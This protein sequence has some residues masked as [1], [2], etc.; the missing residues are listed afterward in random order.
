METIRHTK[1]SSENQTVA[2]DLHGNCYLNITNRCTLRCRFCP[3]FNKQWDVQSYSL[4]LTQEPD[5]NEVLNAVGDPSQYQQIVFCGLGESTLRLVDVLGIAG[6]IKN[7]GGRVRINTDGLINWVK[8]ED[9]TPLFSGVIDALSISLNAQNETVY[10]SHCRPPGHGAYPAL[11]DFIY[12]VRA[13]VENI[14]VTAIDGLEGVD[15]DACKEIADVLGVVFRS[16]KLD[17]VG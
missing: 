15:I 17:K 3:K 16:R 6:E 14:T 4:R 1:R 10:S 8:Q 9:V 7:Q 11:L 5:I 12:R 2:Y 13:Q